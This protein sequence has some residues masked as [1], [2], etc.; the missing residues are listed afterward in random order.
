MPPK[1]NGETEHDLQD[2]DF[3]KAFQELN[4]GEQTASALENHLAV[5]EAKIDELLAATG[6]QDHSQSS[7]SGSNSTSQNSSGQQAS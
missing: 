3:A 6:Q 1:Q 7:T 4:R 5:L 2:A